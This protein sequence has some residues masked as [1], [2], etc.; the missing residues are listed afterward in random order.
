MDGPVTWYKND[1]ILSP[2]SPASWFNNDTVLRRIL[3]RIRFARQWLRFKYVV[4]EDTGRYSCRM[5][6]PETEPSKV[7]WRNITVKV[8]NLQNDG[9]QEEIGQL[10]PIR[11]PITHEETNE[12]DIETRS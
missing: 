12:L 5:E 1:T 4:L 3:P 11:E 6:I 8:E 7:Y 2:I 10:Q 9:Y